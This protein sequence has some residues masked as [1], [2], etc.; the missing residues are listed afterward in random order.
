M[1]SVGYLFRREIMRFLS[2]RNENCTVSAAQAIV[3]GLS[4]EGGLFVPATFPSINLEQV[5]KRSGYP[6]IA[7]MIMEPFLTD[8]SREFLL[9]AAFKAYGKAFNNKAA[10]LKKVKDK[11]FSLEL[12]HG[13]TCAFKDY[14]LQLMPQLLIEGKRILQ[15]DE[16]THILVATS[17]DTGKAALEG[18]KNLP[19]IHISVF[20]PHNGTSEVQRLQMAT[21]EGENVTVYAVEG[22]FDDVQTALKQVFGNEKIQKE[23]LEKNIRLSSANSINWG[24][25]VP[26]IAYYFAAYKQLVDQNE[27]KLGE[28]V[29]FC[30]PTGNFGDILA[31][32]YAKQMG[33][34]I[35]KLICAS[36]QNNVLTEFLK[37]GLYDARRE[38]YRTTSPSMDILVSSN[39]ERLLYH[40]TNN[41]AQ[42][43]KWMEELREKG[44]YQIDEESLK[45]IKQ[46]FDAGYA[47]DILT[48]DQLQFEFEKEGYL[49][50]THTAV[51]FYVA[52]QYQSKGNEAIP[53]IVLSTASPFKFPH[54]VMKALKQ[55]TR[56]DEFE[57]M[58]QL[59]IY[60]NEQIPE[61]L[62]NLRDLPERFKQVIKPKEIVEIAKTI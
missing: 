16:T 45:E 57:T 8:Y 4:E 28:S 21:Q 61:N 55:S 31:G 40:V 9:N 22:N 33:L 58:A 60:T 3:Q 42:V 38:F 12:W 23:L 6:E 5:C 52:K 54:D 32:Y 26:Q 14:A 2:T 20:Y 25:L 47:D 49:C 39:L 36:N 37:T 43:K 18:Y 46:M 11:L 62:A 27:I 19:G 53:M 35:H 29:D 30:V 34:P 10:Y 7:A 15:C 56:Q 24:R 13:P 17:G 59:S 51:A 48:A 50:D 44:Y 41:A 1:Q